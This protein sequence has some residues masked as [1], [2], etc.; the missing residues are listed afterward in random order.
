MGGVALADCR[1]GACAGLGVVPVVFI[2]AGC[3]VFLRA[4]K[5]GVAGGVYHYLCL[6]PRNAGIFAWATGSV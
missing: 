4:E 5:V 3:V 1:A 2:T 6:A